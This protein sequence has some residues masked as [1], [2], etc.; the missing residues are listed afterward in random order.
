M[1]IDML[2]IKKITSHP[3]K[4]PRQFNYGLLIDNK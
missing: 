4:I 2:I 1:S 3:N